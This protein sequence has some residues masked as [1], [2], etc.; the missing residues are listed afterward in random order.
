M[1]SGIHFIEPET[2]RANICAGRCDTFYD[3]NVENHHAH[4]QS[5]SHGHYPHLIPP[6]CCVPKPGT[7]RSL[8]ILVRDGNSQFKTGYLE[9][10]IA[11]ECQC[12]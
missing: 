1:A 4:I 11:T 5:L 9:D 7:L 6:P 3:E 2:F 10:M 8:N 12:L